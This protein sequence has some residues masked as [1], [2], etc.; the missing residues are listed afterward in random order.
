M[1]TVPGDQ[2][3]ACTY[4]R[5]RAGAADGGPGEISP[6]ATVVLVAGVALHGVDADAGDLYLRGGMGLERSSETV[7]ADRDCSSASPVAL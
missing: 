2:E 6:V 1:Q 5:R 4:F 7:F 3:T